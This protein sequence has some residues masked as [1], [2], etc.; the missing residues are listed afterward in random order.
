MLARYLV[1]VKQAPAAKVKEY[2]GYCKGNAVTFVDLTKKLRLITAEEIAAIA[3]MGVEDIVCS[4]FLWRKGEYRFD[5]QPSVNEH[6][7]GAVSLT[8]DAAAMEA[9]RRADEWPRIRKLI[10]DGSVAALADPRL[11]QAN[12]AASALTSPES[13]LLAHL[14]GKRTVGELKAI[15]F[16]SEYRIYETLF[17]AVQA[18]KARV[19]GQGKGRIGR[20]IR[21]ES[22]REVSNVTVAVLT[23]ALLVAGVLLAGLV[24]LPKVVFHKRHEVAVMERR[25]L[26]EQHSSYKASVG[27]LV[28]RAERGGSVSDLSELVRS[29]LLGMRDIPRRG[30]SV[31]PDSASR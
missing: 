26:E 16:W 31:S 14:D 20:P 7:V 6:V 8:T 5:P 28:Y 15:L 21:E 24:A 17:G 12:I 23:T 22:A 18:G 25:M 19:L 10:N 29:G 13:Y 27:F 3:Q 1:Y 11:G 9:M 4:L 2:A 30:A